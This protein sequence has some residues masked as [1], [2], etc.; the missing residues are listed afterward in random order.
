MNFKFKM[1]RN[2]IDYEI[3]CV[4]QE[5]GTVECLIPKGMSMETVAHL[6]TELFVHLGN[7]ISDV[8]VNFLDSEF[9]FEKGSVTAPYDALVLMASGIKQ[10]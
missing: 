6:V 5:G 7:E 1:T 2:E 3:Q 8:K 10:F 4:E 9:K